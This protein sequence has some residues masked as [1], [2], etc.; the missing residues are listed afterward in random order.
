MDKKVITNPASSE[1]SGPECIPPM[2]LKNCDP[3]LCYI[4]AELLNKNF[5]YLKDFI[6]G[7]SI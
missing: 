4:L 7:P 2:V 1:A 5:R 3:E 6:G